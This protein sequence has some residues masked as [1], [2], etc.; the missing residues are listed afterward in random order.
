MP[1]FT[2]AT[3]RTFPRAA[4]KIIDAERL[5]RVPAYARYYHFLGFV[6][7][8]TDD[9]VTVAVY[10]VYDGPMWQAVIVRKR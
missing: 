1:A 3:L 7:E 10:G 5:C 4:V 6:A 8:Q 9:T 2:R